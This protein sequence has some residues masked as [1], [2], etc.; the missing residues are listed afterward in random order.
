MKNE[1]HQY[2]HFVDL[3][4]ELTSV[5]DPYCVGL[6]KQHNQ[7]QQK[8]M[9]NIQH[10]RE[11]KGKEKALSILNRFSF[12]KVI[13]DCMGGFSLYQNDNL[14]EQEYIDEQYLDHFNQ[15]INKKRAEHIKV[16]DV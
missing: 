4:N 8:Y 13:E 3:R 7:Q 16:S 6:L 9:Y 1:G 11:L 14:C 12:S 15:N 5:I 2:V 10:I